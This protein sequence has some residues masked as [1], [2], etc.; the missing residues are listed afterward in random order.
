MIIQTE[1]I[2]NDKNLIGH[3]VLHSITDAA[4]N[5]A[6]DDGQLDVRMTING[7]SVDLQSFVDHWQSQV[8]RMISDVAKERLEDKFS[9]IN[10]M[11]FEL[12]RKLEVELG[13]REEW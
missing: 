1:D 6:H 3:I 2:I 13:C 11:M 12:Q 10:D 4:A 7:D 8:D 9:P 5:A